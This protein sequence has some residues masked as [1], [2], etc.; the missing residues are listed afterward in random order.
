MALFV[1]ALSTAAI[2][3]ATDLIADYLV[4]RRR[5]QEARK[6]LDLAYKKGW[7]H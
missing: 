4:E 1:V 6:R 5:R 2:L 7:R 3:L